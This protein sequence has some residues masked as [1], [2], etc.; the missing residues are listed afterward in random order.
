MDKKYLALFDLD[1]TL[2]DTSEVNY[3]AYRDALEIFGISLDREYFIRECNGRHYKEFLPNIMGTDE[4]VE[5]VHQYKKDNY[6]QNLD[7]AIENKHLFAMA[8]AMCATYHL[9]VVTT[10]SRKNAMDILSYFGYENLF[11]YIVTQEDITRV[12]PDPEGF[13][14]AMRHFNALPT[15]TIIFEDSEVGIQAAQATGASVF[16][17]RQFI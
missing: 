12:K 15:N 2:F 9:A 6:V 7:K 13:E 10:A 16:S 3:N 8:K 5:K 14:I 4:F 1:G 17:V 11:E